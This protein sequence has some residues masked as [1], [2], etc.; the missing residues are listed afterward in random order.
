MV[1]PLGTEFWGGLEWARK[2]ILKKPGYCGFPLVGGKARKK[3][4][5]NSS[6]KIYFLLSSYNYITTDMAT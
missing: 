4:D 5:I 1:N 3:S 2:K 6:P